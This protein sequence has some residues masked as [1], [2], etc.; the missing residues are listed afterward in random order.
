[1]L[2]TDTVDT[3]LLA[4]NYTRIARSKKPFTELV[5]A[6]R[7]G[8]NACLKALYERTAGFVIYTDGN[9]DFE[10]KSNWN[11]NA[12]LEDTVGELYPFVADLVETMI[13]KKATEV[14]VVF[15]SKE[16]TES[17]EEADI[18]ELHEDATEEERK[19][20]LL[21]TY[22]KQATRY[23]T[24]NY[25]YCIAIKHTINRKHVEVQYCKLVEKNETYQHNLQKQPMDIREDK[26]IVKSTT[27]DNKNKNKKAKI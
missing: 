23:L 19:A 2:N 15:R 26:T 11:G 9:S 25:A 7:R 3:W 27:I 6:S 10:Y 21:A 8:F 5:A 17:K 24:E 14:C 12:D 18:E 1:M 16:N 4:Y 13:R 22:D 20:H